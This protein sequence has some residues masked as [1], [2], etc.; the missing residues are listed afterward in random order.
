MLTSIEGKSVIVT[1]SSKGIGKGIAS[2]FAEKGAKVLIV[3]RNLDPAQA[4][5]AEI[6]AAGGTAAAFSAD[7]SSWDDMQQMAEA[8]VEHLGGIDILCCNAGIFPDAKLSEMT[9][10]QWDEVMG[11]NLKGTFLGVRACLPK[12][13]ERGGGRVIVTSSITGPITGYPGW[14]HYGASKSGQLGFIKT[15]A[16]ELSPHNI[17]IN[18]IMPGNIATEGLDDLGEEYLQKMTESIPM[19]KLG[20]VEDVAYA[21]LF[22]ASKE[23]AYITGQ[24][25]VI[26]GGQ[27]LPESLMALEDI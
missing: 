18:A 20:T 9:P 1:G 23:A 10:E 14:C 5:A 4:T 3:A 11:V 6:N 8:A 25:L 17:T 27:V 16:I 21:A 26:D 2:V 7:V 22:F 12:M 24:T 13:K 15:A 19:K